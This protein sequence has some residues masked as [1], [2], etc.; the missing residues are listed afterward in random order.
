MTTRAELI[1]DLDDWLARDDLSA[2]GKEDTFLRIAQAQINRKVRVRNREVTT[3]LIASARTAALPDDYQSMRAIALDSTL[4]RRVEYLTPERIRESPIWNNQG[5]FRFDRDVTPT[6]YTIEANNLVFAPEPTADN[7]ITFYLV[8]YAKFDDL[9]NGT[10][11]N[12]LLTNAYDVYLWAILHAAAI[13]LQETTLAGGYAGL[14]KQALVD[15][16]DSERFGRF[17]GSNLFSTG[18]PRRVV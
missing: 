5:G 18:S 15:L 13:F 14:F 2:G 4:D 10:D 16:A 6:A 12:W 8:Y 3:T 1:T 9:V 11:T 7:P 17:S